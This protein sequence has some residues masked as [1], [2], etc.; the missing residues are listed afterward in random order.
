MRARAEDILPLDATDDRSFEE[1]Y[2]I[3]VESIPIREQKPKA[4]IAA[5]VRRPDYR[6]LLAKRDG[7]VIGFSVLFLPLREPFG[8]L[9]YMAVQAADRD[10]GVGAA[11]FHRSLQ[12]IASLQGEAP[13]LLEVDS[14]LSSSPER[15]ILQRRQRFYRRLGCRRVE[16]LSYLLPLPTEAPPPEMDLLVYV[17]RSIRSLPKSWLERWLK[18]VYQEAYG[19]SPEDARIVRMLEPVAD[20]ARLV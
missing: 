18:I 12:E 5:M 16:G 13:V 17:P 19:C 1:L 15:E 9:E 10:G 8:L 2:R 3:Y 4:E 14:E 6:I 20:P 11:L 7:R